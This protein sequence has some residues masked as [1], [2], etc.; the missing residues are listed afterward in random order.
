MIKQE[1]LLLGAGG[2]ARACID[3][4]ENTKQYSV[5]GLVTN[6]E[7]RNQQNL[8]YPVIGSD[9]DLKRAKEHV[10]SFAKEHDCKAKPSAVLVTP[11][12]TRIPFCKDGEPNII[13]YRDKDG[14]VLEDTV[15]NIVK[16]HIENSGAGEEIGR[17]GKIEDLQIFDFKI[18]FFRISNFSY[19][20]IFVYF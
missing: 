6:E 16:Y 5:V 3:V 8:D 1:I 15:A 18:M 7:N 11:R 10:D 13:T 20:V 19:F 9:A 12:G 14:N 17:F 2:H 4:I